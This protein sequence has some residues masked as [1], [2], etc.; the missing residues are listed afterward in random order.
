M[1]DNL[2]DAPL[3][4]LNQSSQREPYLVLIVDDEES[5][6]SS[7]A[8]FV[9]MLGYPV[10]IALH[11]KAALTLAHHRWPAL[12]ITD[13][14]MPYLTGAQLIA[15]LIEEAKQTQQ[16]MPITILITAA[17]RRVT[18][19]SHADVVIGKSFELGTIEDLLKRFLGRAPLG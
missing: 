4:P 8:A 11:G 17:S 15:A 3:L 1:S 13:Q 19:Q 7:L 6:A 18:E 16:P 14:M 5:I 12:V 2:Q 10:I 9:E